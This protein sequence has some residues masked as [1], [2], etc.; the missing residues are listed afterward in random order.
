MKF[1][2]VFNFSYNQNILESIFL[3][4]LPHHK[5]FILSSRSTHMKFNGIKD[6]I[7]YIISQSNIYFYKHLIIQIL[8]DDHVL[9]AKKINL[10][11][12]LM[13]LD[14]YLNIFLENFIQIKMQKIVLDNH[15]KN[16]IS[17][18]FKNF[19]NN[20]TYFY[21]YKT[22]LND[23]VVY[24]ESNNYSFPPFIITNYLIEEIFTYLMYE[25]EDIS[26]YLNNMEFYSVMYKTKENSVKSTFL[27]KLIPSIFE[28]FKVS[29]LTLDEIH[30]D[31]INKSIYTIQKQA[32]NSLYNPEYK[33]C[34]SILF[35]IYNKI[36]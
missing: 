7:D 27:Y 15:F 2:I 28:N 8:S 21:I 26:I 33:L 14:N 35:D 4:Y 19:L 5:F 12:N 13:Y 10:F 34:R 24:I 9:F 6:I 31:L 17:I 18:T 32:V 36:I 20:K 16:I 25:N 1:D 29:K 22:Y 23:T 30:N 11:R 3:K